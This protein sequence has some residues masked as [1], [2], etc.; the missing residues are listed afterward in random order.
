MFIEITLQNE[1][2]FLLLFM[3]NADMFTCC[4]L[5]HLQDESIYRCTTEMNQKN[6]HCCARP[7]S[8]VFCDVTASP[9]WLAILNYFSVS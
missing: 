4:H 9:W 7:Q 5:D 3:G 6:A 2:V 1:K 8:D